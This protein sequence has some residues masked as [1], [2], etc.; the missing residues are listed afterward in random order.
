MNTTTAEL[1]PNNVVR[2]TLKRFQ[3]RCRLGLLLVTCAL[4]MT[5][6]SLV[7]LVVAIATLFK[8]R[9]LYAEGIAARLGRIGLRLAG[10]RVVVHQD[11]PLPATQTIYISNHTSTLDVFVL[12]SLGLPNA[13]FFLYGKLRKILPLA[14]IGYL[15][16]IFW[17]VSQEFPKKRTRIFQRAGRVLRRTGESVYLS[18]EGTRVASGDI[19]HFNKGAFHLAT[20]LGAPI[21]PI[22][23]SI[24]KA[25]NPGRGYRFRPGVVDVYFKP[26]ISTKS[27]KL[28]DLDRN[29][30]V[31]RD[32]FVRMHEEIGHG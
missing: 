4:I 26:P 27:W 32:L 16:G 12:L 15:I 18:P 8:A 20:D 17:T 9:R 28:E 23:I 29:R 13:R 25:M 10:V 11:D 30:T 1:R 6:G 21:V 7:M 3:E 22:Y 2:D 19:G 14:L 24:P 5:A 31:V